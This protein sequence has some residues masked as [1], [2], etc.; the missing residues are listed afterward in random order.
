MCS[1]NHEMNGRREKRLPT[2]P[3]SICF[4]FSFHIHK[5]TIGTPIIKQYGTSAPSTSTPAR[6]CDPP[7][8]TDIS[9]SPHLPVHSPEHNAYER[10]RTIATLF[11]QEWNDASVLPH[12]SCCNTT[13]T[14]FS[15]FISVMFPQL[16]SIPNSFSH[17]N[18]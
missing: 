13:Q 17:C 1:S 8:S 16:R 5:S 18:L 9:R 3:L 15:F 2:I 10:E 6:I 11:H 14:Q 7:S 12:Y 4:L